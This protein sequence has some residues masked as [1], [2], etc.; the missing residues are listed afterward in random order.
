MKISTNFNQPYLTL[1]VQ[2][3]ETAEAS[4]S[5]SSVVDTQ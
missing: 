3:A 4:E 5:Q 2:V 1:Y